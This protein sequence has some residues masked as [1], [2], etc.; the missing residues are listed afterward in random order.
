MAAKEYE[1]G[2]EGYPRLHFDYDYDDR[3][4]EEARARGHLGGVVVELADGTTH[5]VF[6]Y[7]AVRLAQDLEEET[8]L[9]RPFVAEKGMIV[10]NDITLDNM[11]FAVSALVSQGFFGRKDS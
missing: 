5:D 4:A 1:M 6:F 8:R 9:G 10:L 11:R 3:L 7:D 2:K